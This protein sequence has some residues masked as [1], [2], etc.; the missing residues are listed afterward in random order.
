MEL[1]FLGTGSGVPSKMR[2]VSSLAL[3][4]LQE[5]DEVWLFDCGEATQ[6]QIL[7]SSIK[8]RKISKIFITHMHGDH[9]FGLPG[10]LSS[11]SFQ[12]GLNP[13]EIYGPPRLKEFIEIS[14]KVSETRLKYDLIFKSISQPKL[15]EDHHLSVSSIPLKHGIPSCGYIIEEK[16]SVGPLLPDK[17]KSLGVKPGPIYQDIKNNEKVRLSDGTIIYRDDVTGPPIKGRKVSI[18]GDTHASDD[19]I[20]H[21]ADSDLLIH[22]A[23]FIHEDQE[24]ARKYFHS[25]S[26]QAAQIAKEANVKQLILN[27]I[28]S[29]YLHE[30]LQKELKQI[31]Q[32]FPNTIYAEDLSSY[33][34][35]KEG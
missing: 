1:T 27:H 28:S 12:E 17:L 26:L 23:T 4:M 10:L 13:V 8:P 15:F 19:I 31:K 32:T 20:E 18:L 14:L 6:H 5:R 3:S 34:I 33:T 22:E 29:R 21:V 7:H 30:D 11:R 24:L 25:T 9:I 16:D 2:N 35:Q